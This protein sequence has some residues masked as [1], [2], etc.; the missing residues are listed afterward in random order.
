M[1]SRRYLS[2]PREEEED[3]ISI[4]QSLTVG[5]QYFVY[6]SNVFTYTIVKCN[7]SNVPY[8]NHLYMGQVVYS[9]H[10]ALGIC[11]ERH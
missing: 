8:H 5:Q 10:L 7:I 4:P 2:R 9:G 11:T 6:K 1:R 3:S